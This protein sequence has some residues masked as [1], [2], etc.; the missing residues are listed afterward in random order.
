M[1]YPLKNLGA[2]V[3]I[4]KDL[5]IFCVAN[6]D[7]EKYNS[8]SQRELTETYIFE[9]QFK[10]HYSYLCA[11]AFCMV[12]DENAARDIVQDFFLYCWRK[13]NAIKI[14]HTFKS[15]AVRAV[16]NASLNYLKKANRTKLE[17]IHTI[18]GRIKDFHPEDNMEGDTKNN[19]LWTAV[20][21]LPE[22]RKKIFLLSNID[23]LKYQEIADKLGISINTVKT[24]IKLA[25][26]FLRTECGW[27]MKIL[28]LIIAIKFSVCFTHF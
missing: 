11:V 21:K 26:Q 27:M 6:N 20:S 17:E 14:T 1:N 3:E 2:A 18:E 7:T 28:I 13:R 15:Y 24:Q 8:M 25:L 22:Q 10:M 4:F 9:E 23:G 16:R 12:E 19:A 5:S